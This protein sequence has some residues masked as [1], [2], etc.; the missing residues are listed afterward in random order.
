MTKAP[1]ELAR[2]WLISHGYSTFADGT[3]QYKG[4]VAD[5]EE[6]LSAYIKENRF[7]EQNKEF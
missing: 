6:I 7:Y 5:P 1:C 4:Y 3:W 2:E